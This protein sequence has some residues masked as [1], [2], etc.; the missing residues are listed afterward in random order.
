[1]W[2]VEL[3]RLMHRVRREDRRLA[4]ASKHQYAMPRRMPSRCL[5]RHLVRQLKGRIEQFCQPRVQDRP[6]AVLEYVVVNRE[7]PSLHAARL[8][9]FPP[10]TRTNVYHTQK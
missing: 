10:T 3:H 1:M 2:F 9:E 7:F 6:D 8:H 4:A 5:D